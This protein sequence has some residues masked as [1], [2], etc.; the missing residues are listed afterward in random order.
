M[1]GIVMFL[2]IKLILK[3]KDFCVGFEVGV[4]LCFNVFVEEC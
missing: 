4:I 1:F 3:C 2:I